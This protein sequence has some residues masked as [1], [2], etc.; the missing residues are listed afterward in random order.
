[1]DFSKWEDNH[2]DTRGNPAYHPRVLLRPIILGYVEGLA[3]DCAILQDV[4][5]QMWLIFILCGFD[6]PDFRTINWFL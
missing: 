6:A 2:W 4:F 3:S 1:M 5:A